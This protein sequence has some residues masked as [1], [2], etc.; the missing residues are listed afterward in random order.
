M[1]PPHTHTPR[2]EKKINLEEIEVMSF[3]VHNY[4][5]LALG[6]GKELLG[7]HGVCVVCDVYMVCVVYVCVVV[8]C[9]CVYIYR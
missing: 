1:H 5:P 2:G 7:S 3:V 8:W 6:S 4:F 9:V